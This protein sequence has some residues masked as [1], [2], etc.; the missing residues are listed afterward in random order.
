MIDALWSHP[1]L[2]AFLVFGVL[3]AS[4]IGMTLLGMRIGGRTRGEEGR[5]AG[6]AAVEG[7]V[8][9]LFGLLVAF[10]FAGAAERFQLRKILILQEAQAIGTAWSRLDLLPDPD[11]AKLRELFRDYLDRRLAA[12]ARPRDLPSFVREL[13]DADEVGREILSTSAAAC[14]PVS[15]QPFAEV[16]MPAVNAMSDIALAR[17]AA[18]RAHPPPVIFALLFGVS[19]AAAFLVGLAMSPSKRKSWI[20]IAGFGALVAATL[21]VI[22]DLELPRLGLVR[23]EKADALLREVRRS[24]DLPPIG[25]AS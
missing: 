2:V 17:N 16:I 21:Y 15:G 4:L 9:A 8:L 20:H 19:L 12:Y 23:V 1:Y 22:A 24:M 13:A 6:T 25:P 5:A 18:L 11:R 14:R 3:T 10:T 7:S